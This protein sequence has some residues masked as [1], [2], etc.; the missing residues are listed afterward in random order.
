MRLPRRKSR[1][2]RFPRTAE[3]GGA[4]ERNR[5]GL[6]MRTP[7]SARPEMRRSRLSM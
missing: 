1:R 5:N 7:S 6:A 3:S 4:T 2:T